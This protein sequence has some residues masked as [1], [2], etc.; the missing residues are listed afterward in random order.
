MPEPNVI[1]NTFVIERTYP[2]PRARV[3]AAFADPAKKRRWYAESPN[4]E[5]EDFSM[6]FR[7]GGLE[8]YTFRFNATAPFPGVTLENEGSYHDIVP[9]QRIV[10]A[11]TMSLGGNR[12]SCSL[13]TI[14]LVAAESGTVLRCTHQGVFFEGSGGPAMREAG[15]RAL[16]DRL[17]A[18]LAR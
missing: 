14:E 12:I 18:E 3:F 1:H 10:T 5:I 8:R 15:W 2:Q 6:Q 13:V 4:H 7:V 11:S 9:E 17:A 16:F